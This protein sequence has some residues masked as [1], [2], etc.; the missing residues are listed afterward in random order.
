MLGYRI[1]RIILYLFF[2]FK[3]RL[4]HKKGISWWEFC[5]NIIIFIQLRYELHTDGGPGPIQRPFKP[6]EMGFMPWL[7]F[8]KKTHLHHPISL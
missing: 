5:F 6:H 1:N 7:K 3:E 2:I 8:E 4:I